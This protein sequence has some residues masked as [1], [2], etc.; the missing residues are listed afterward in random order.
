MKKSKSIVRLTLVLSF[1][2]SMIVS[3]NA[4][5]GSR[6]NSHSSSRGGDY[7]RAGRG[8]SG[9][10]SYGARTYSYPSVRSYG[11]AREY[12]NYSYRS[13]IIGRSHYLPFAYG[14]R[15]YNVPRGSI[16]I[17]FGGNPY[18]YYGGSFYRP[19]GGYYQTIFPPIGIRIGALPFGYMPVYVGPDPYYFYN[20]TYYR[21]YDNSYEVVDAPMGAQISALPKGAKSVLV[22]GEKFYELNGTYYKEDRNAKGQIVY[23][24]VGKN[25]EID[26][27]E[28]SPA[29]AGSGVGSV[30]P[31]LPA[32][33]KS[34]TLNGEKLYVS[35]DNTYYRAEQNGSF[36]VVGT[37]N[38]TNL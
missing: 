28:E 38:Q 25:G 7:A 4:Q 21:Q 26:N 11:Y 33:C 32:D 8:F 13:P 10:R 18:Y 5:R 12:N 24:V 6:G 9:P 16:S 22:N 20:G 34:I 35:P 14:P 37:A 17:T 2:V 36:T 19:F 30:V 27:S 1:A 23:T 15:Y 29:P 3:A 31:R